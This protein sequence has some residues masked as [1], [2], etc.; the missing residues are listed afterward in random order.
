M[1]SKESLLGLFS[2][3]NLSSGLAN[4]L[5][6]LLPFL[7]L[8]LCRHQAWVSFF[9]SSPTKDISPLLYS[10]KRRA[11]LLARDGMIFPGTAI[12]VLQVKCTEILRCL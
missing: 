4:P 12:L 2:S 10:W 7:C 3:I 6:N 1:S 9:S 5:L 8:S 11:V